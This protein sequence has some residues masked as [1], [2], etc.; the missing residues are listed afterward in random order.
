MDFGT[1]IL[2]LDQ[3]LHWGKF[4]L[5]FRYSRRGQ[6]LPV[7]GCAPTLCWILHLTLLSSL[8]DFMN[9]SNLLYRLWNHLLDR[10]VLWFLHIGIVWVNTWPKRKMVRRG[11]VLE[12]LPWFWWY[13]RKLHLIMQELRVP[14]SFFWMHKFG[15]LM[16]FWQLSK[17]HWF[18]MI[19][20]FNT[21]SANNK[22]LAG[23]YLILIAQIFLSLNLNLNP[24]GLYSWRFYSLFVQIIL[25]VSGHKKDR[26]RILK[27]F[28]V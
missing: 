13:R 17:R 18:Q 11:W 3:S 27:I 7:I 5:I 1:K 22:I 9:S 28:L 2:L 4:E 19:R 20:I 14:Q 23:I 24:E 8:F 21:K 26:F 10:V 12:R 15:Q 16:W 25:L 6:R